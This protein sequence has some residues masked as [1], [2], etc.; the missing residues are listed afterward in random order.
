MTTTYSVFMLLKAT[1]HWHS[2]A[3][4]ERI[5][6]R[7]DALSRVF[8]HFAAVTLRFFDASGLHADCS[9]VLIWETTDMAE[10]RAAVEALQAHAFFG[11]PCFEV[12]DVIPTLAEEWPAFPWPAGGAPA[13]AAVL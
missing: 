13:R 5:A 7:D 6:I 4:E 3:R 12:V 2:L 1:P 10:Y 8:N 11:A 9:E